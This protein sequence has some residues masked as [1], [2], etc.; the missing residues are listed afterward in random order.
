M[1][2]QRV[3]SGMR[4]TGRLHIGHYHGA[5]KNWVDLQNKYECFY[6]VADLHALTTD[7]TDTKK[8]Q[9]YGIDNVM[10]WIACGVDPEKATIFVQSHVKEHAEL[11]LIFGMITPLGWLERNPTY[12]DMK[13]ML[14]Q[15]DLTNFGFLGYPV[16]QAADIV[17]YKANYVP[18]GIDQAP[19]VELT[20]EIA[21]RF[22]TLYKNIFPEPRT[23]LTD[24]PKILGLDNQ[25][26]SKSL[27]NALYLSDD[28]SE[29]EKKILSM[30]T[31]PHRIKRSDP[32]NPDI[33]N[34]FTYHKM[35]SPQS[36]IDNVNV[37]CRRAGIGCFE[38]KKQL[39]KNFIEY[40]KPIY[41]ARS[42]LDKKYILDIIHEGDKK[43]QKIAKATMEEVRDALH[44]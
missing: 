29:T 38:D 22:N 26:M 36:M 3:L 20:R 4:P 30:F 41:E 21:R 5:L 37:E 35:Y 32:G 7:F 1:Q 42:K 8:I 12:K 44:I 39:A 10:D 13:E 24:T 43:A 11:A 14:T 33:C 17:M 6:F 19:H 25:K 27:N 15:K 2:K 23:L 34:V 18:V 40:F 28:P 16:L 9:D 31:D